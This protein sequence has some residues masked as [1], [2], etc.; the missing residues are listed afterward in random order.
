MDMEGKQTVLVDRELLELLR[1]CE[2][3]TGVKL[4]I[5][6]SIA[7]AIKLHLRRR[8]INVLIIHLMKMNSEGNSHTELDNKLIELSELLDIPWAYTQMFR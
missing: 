2:S 8:K 4:S 7:A 5:E 6:D 3:D 1:S